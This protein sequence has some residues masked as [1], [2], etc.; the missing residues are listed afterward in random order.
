MADRNNL[1]I[2]VF[3]KD[4]NFQK[5]LGTQQL[6]YPQDVKVTPISVVVLDESQ[7]GIHFFSRSGDL[8]RSCVTEGQDGMVYR[9]SFFSLDPAGNI[10]ISDCLRHNI[11]ILSPS[12]QMIHTIGNEGHGRGE[13]Y[14]PWGICLSQTGNILVISDNSNYAL[15]SF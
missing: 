15:Q 11:K 8:I 7:N 12:G 3:S 2:S 13:L 1:R 6:K 5:H 10:F 14:Q 9:L 4:L